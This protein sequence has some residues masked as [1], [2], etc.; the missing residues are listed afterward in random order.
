MRRKL[1]RP[2]AE[3]VLIKAT[4]DNKMSYT[5]MLE[6]K[7][8][9]SPDDVGSKV[10]KIRK[11]RDGNLLIELRMDSKLGEVSGAIRQAVGNQMLV[12]PMVPTVTI[13]LRDLEETTTEE[14]IREAFIAALVEATPDQVE[15]KALRARPRGM[16]VALVVAPRAIATAKGLKPGK[17]RVGWV[18]TTAGEKKLVIRFFKCL[19]FG[20]VAAKCFK[21]I[22]EKLCYKCGDPG[23]LAAGCG[24]PYKCFACEATGK[25][26]GHRMGD[27]TC[28]AL[29]I[30]MGKL[31]HHQNGNG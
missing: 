9:A 21:D 31:D 19:E 13:E 26:Q 25:P 23:H 22:T 24:K 7:T 1:P 18:N 30:A 17:V 27:V 12:R 14:E 29:R 10:G 11:T 20:H 8:K 5:D 3:A 2:K 6:R 28:A 16:K 15:V 4:A